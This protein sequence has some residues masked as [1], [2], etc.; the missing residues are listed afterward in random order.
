MW[1]EF[2]GAGVPAPRTTA[3]ITR[4]RPWTWELGCE[5]LGSEPFIKLVNLLLIAAFLGLHGDEASHWAECL[6]AEN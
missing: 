1:Q 3:S 6:Y 4:A 5:N 2:I